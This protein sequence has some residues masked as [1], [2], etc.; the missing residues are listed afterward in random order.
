ML[1]TAAPQRGGRWRVLYRQPPT[2]SEKKVSLTVQTPV[3]PVDVQAQVPLQD[4]F[5]VSCHVE[6]EEV[7]GRVGSTQ[8][9]E[10]VPSPRL[11]L[12]NMANKQQI[13]VATPFPLQVR[14]TH[15]RA[16]VGE[17]GRV[18]QQPAHSG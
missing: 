11:E 5:V 12:P 10:S 4:A 6:R 1:S 8:D 18:C 2:D 15:L 14:H 9:I 7:G 13:T 16:V 17:D 3:V